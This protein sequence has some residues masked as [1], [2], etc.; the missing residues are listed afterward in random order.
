MFSTKRRENGPKGS[1][2]HRCMALDRC[3]GADGSSRDTGDGGTRWI[4]GMSSSVWNLPGM[5]PSC[6]RTY[7]IGEYNRRLAGNDLEPERNRILRGRTCLVWY[8]PN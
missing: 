5:G 4:S 3:A 2:H 1:R 7:R 6:A 8:C